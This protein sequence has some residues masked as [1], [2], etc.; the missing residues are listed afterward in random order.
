MVSFVFGVSGSWQSSFPISGVSAAACACSYSGARQNL[1]QMYDSL[2]K[3]MVW[4]DDA[5]YKTSVPDSWQMSGYREYQRLSCADSLRLCL[6]LCYPRL[7]MPEKWL[8]LQIRQC[9]M[10]LEK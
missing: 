10:L 9:L 3:R 1:Q 8:C 4:P 5:C 6:S 7:S 2:G